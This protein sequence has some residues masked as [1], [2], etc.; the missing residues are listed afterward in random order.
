MPSPNCACVKKLSCLTLSL[1][2]HTQHYLRNYLI[3]FNIK[4]SYHIAQK[5]LNQKC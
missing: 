5:L 1:Q 3:S 2:K 4:L